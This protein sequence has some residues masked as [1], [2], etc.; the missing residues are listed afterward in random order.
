MRTDGPVETTSGTVEAGQLTERYRART[1]QEDGRLSAE[2]RVA[3]DRPLSLRIREIRPNDEWGQ[4]YG[5]SVFLDGT[6]AHVR[7][8]RSPETGGGPYLSTFVET[9]DPAI[10]SDGKVTVTIE[11]TSSAPTHVDELWSYSDLPG[12]VRQQGMRVPDRM[13]FVLGQ[14]YKGEP[15]FRQRLDYV[16]SAIHE[17]AVVER[18][19]AVLDYFPKRTPAQLAANYALWRKL[20]REYDLPFAIESTSDWEGTP[21]GVPDGKGGTFADLKYQQVLWSPQDQTGPDKDVW[22]GQRLPD[23]LGTDYEPRYGL[24]VPNIWGN[25]PWLTWNNDDLNAFY[26][27]KANQSID[28]VRPLVWDMQ[29][30]DED[31]RLLQFSTTMESTYWSKRAGK[32][33]ADQAYT[34]YNSGVPRDDL[35][36]DYNPATVEMA[37]RDG[38]TLDPTDGLSDAEM[39]WLYKNQS[40]P[41]QLFADIYYSGLP[42][43]RIEVSDGRAAFPT[44]LLRHNVHSEVYSRLQEPYWDSAHPSLTQGI[45]RHARPGSEYIELDN[46]SPGGF[47][48]LQKMREFGRLA[49]PNLENSVSWYG[50]EKTMLLRQLH[51]NGSRYTSFYNWQSSGDDEAA[52]WINSFVDNPHPW[53]FVRDGTPDGRIDG[54]STVR[55]TFTAGDLGPMDTLRVRVERNR[56]AAANPLRATVLDDQGRTIATR[57]LGSA[58]L[59]DDG[60][61]TFG[62]PVAELHKS[63]TYTVELTQDSDPAYAFPTI[64]GEPALRIGLDLAAE[65]D[66]SLVIQWRRD[67]ADAI[68]NVHGDLAD[69]DSRAAATLDRA[70]GLLAANRYVA[71][72]HLAMKADALR[73]PVL[74]QI[75]EG[76]TGQLTPFGLTVRTADGAAVD[77][78]VRSYAADRQ[79]ELTMRGYAT[80]TVRV[81][82]DNAEFGDSP[83]VEVDGSEVPVLEGEFAVSLSDTA[84]HHIRI[85]ATP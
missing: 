51:V 40:Y 45:L 50:P 11:S 48:H 84:P 19:F 71:A 6:L 20:A 14:D 49:N 46:Y 26:E 2:L 22:N 73:F 65:R 55:T 64:G 83:V 52:R 12:L 60:W 7:D 29:R 35:Y 59:P 80:G 17:T 61:A 1:L 24:S 4:P 72:Y 56:D 66:R 8:S 85:T 76:S 28:Q 79:A 58:E 75:A 5:F 37:A 53:D 30:A 78:D 47:S 70:R 67:A 39:R 74:Y 62:V 43:E 54:Q 57:R 32:G 82:V 16:R 41:Q 81:H 36:A 3:P 13:V 15:Y 21:T 68:A 42:R 77:A 10:L 34:D 44:E 63:T 69:A 31:G 38:V 27:R 23:L 9:S 33:V 18:G 25:T